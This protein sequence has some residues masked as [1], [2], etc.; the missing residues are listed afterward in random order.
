MQDGADREKKP[1]I[2][3]ESI[4]NLRKVP[5]SGKLWLIDNE[6][7]LLDGYELMYKDPNMAHKF[8]TFHSRML[9]TMCVFRKGLVRKV[10]ALAGHADP[11][12]VLLHYTKEYEPLYDR[13]PKVSAFQ[14]FE[15]HF[16][17][18]LKD[19]TKWVTE[20]MEK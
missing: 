19:V 1:S 6:S 18:R 10:K 16:H 3:S 11:A 5:D 9:Q 8:R 2:L 15:K 7:G 20:C 12:S 17:S 14:L 4:R 13:L